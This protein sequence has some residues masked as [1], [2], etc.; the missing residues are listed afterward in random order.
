MVSY[1]I[2][3]VLLVLPSIA[4]ATDGCV[5]PEQYTIDRR[6]YVTDVQKEQ[7]PYNT[8]VALVEDGIKYCTGTIIKDE[9]GD[10]YV[11]TARH[12]VDTKNGYAQDRITIQTQDGSQF[13]V[14]KHRVGDYSS[15][16]DASFPG[17]WAIYSFSASP[18]NVPYA[19]LTDKYATAGPGEVAY[20]AMVVGYGSLKIMSDQELS[21]FKQRYVSF[22]RT[23]YSALL[24]NWI[25]TDALDTHSFPVLDFINN[26]LS[27]QEYADLF[28]NRLLKVSKCNYFS[29]GRG[30]GCQIWGGN[31]G[32]PIFG[33]D[34]K[35]FGIVTR[36]NYII[37]GDWHSEMIYSVP[38]FRQRPRESFPNRKIKR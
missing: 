28:Q 5:H 25:D 33:E 38:Q 27:S 18:D 6:C 12:C 31:S 20:N 21:D 22:L 29:Y 13:Q 24:P 14:N 15:L 11:Y 23:E 3:F 19:Q 4:M 34:N 35:L 1:I 30:V 32:G 9:N 8:V 2:T 10:L 17:D 37:G 36:G 7:L 26:G 16:T